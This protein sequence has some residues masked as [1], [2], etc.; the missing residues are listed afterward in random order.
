MVDFNSPYYPYEKVITGANTFKG[1]EDIPYKLLMYLLDL[2]DSKGYVPTD[3]NNRPRVRLAKYLWY[4]GA[5]PLNN[6]LPTPEQKL[7]LIFD[8]LNPVLDT[9]TQ[10]EK[11]P[12]GYRMVWQ[13]IIGQSQTETETEI[14]CYFARTIANTP[15]V[16]SIGIRFEISVNANYETNMKINAYE[17]TVNI[18]QC[19]REA[20]NGVNITGIG[21]V[22]FSRMAHIDNGSGYLYDYGT[23]VGRYVHCSIDWAESNEPEVTIY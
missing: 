10:K 13:K 15:F 21:V 3:D 9:D 8:P 2:P 20:L 22:N 12:K 1:V 16:D 14:K 18:E 6:P 11:H 4:D 5:N 7:S 23:N 17:R 19:I